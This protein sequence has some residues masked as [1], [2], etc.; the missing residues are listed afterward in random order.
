[1]YTLSCL[2]IIE[3]EIIL[4]KHT[5]TFRSFRSKDNEKRIFFAP[6]IMGNTIRME[7]DLTSDYVLLC[8]IKVVCKFPRTLN[9]L[10]RI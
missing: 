7:K 4:F 1:M 2:Y 5:K 10:D 9:I 6:L 8:V 3:R